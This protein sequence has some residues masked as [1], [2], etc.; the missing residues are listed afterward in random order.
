M[1]RDSPEF[2]W[3]SRGANNG[4]RLDHVLG[5]G[6]GIEARECRYVHNVREKKLSDHSMVVIDFQAT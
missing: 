6:G 5:L 4:F 3:Y 2:T 1:N